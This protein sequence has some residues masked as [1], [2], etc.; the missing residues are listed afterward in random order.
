[1]VLVRGEDVR[2]ANQLLQALERSRLIEKPGPTWLIED[3]YDGDF[4]F[5]ANLKNDVR[6]PADAGLVLDHVRR[7]WSN[8]HIFLHKSRKPGVVSEIYHVFSFYIEE[9]VSGRADVVVSPGGDRVNLF[10]QP[11]T[12]D[13]KKVHNL[14]SVQFTQNGS[15]NILGETPFGLIRHRS[16]EGFDQ[17]CRKALNDIHKAWEY[18]ESRG[19]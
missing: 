5:R 16:R 14:L 3:R 13:A 7:L 1:M 4:L 6:V 18:A 10:A 8:P 15:I 17:G 9:S 19:V 12:K 11:D 2:R